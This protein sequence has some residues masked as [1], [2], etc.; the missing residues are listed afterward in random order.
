MTRSLQPFL[1][2]RAY[3]PDVHNTN[4]LLSGKTYAAIRN[5]NDKPPDICKE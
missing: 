5:A 3:N 2:F 4:F 1:A